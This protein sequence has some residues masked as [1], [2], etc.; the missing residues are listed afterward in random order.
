[1]R[2]LTAIAEDIDLRQ[3]LRILDRRKAIIL[4]LLA[5][6]TALAGLI[7]FQ[8]TP[9]YTAEAIV[10]LNLRQTKVVDFESVMS[11]LSPEAS[12]IR[13]EVDVLTSRAMVG[14]VV[15]RLELDG[16]PEFN[17]DLRKDASL[18]DL[19]HPR[20]WLPAELWAAVAP[21]EK[22]LAPERRRILDRSALIDA[23][24]RRLSASN[25]GRSYSIRISFTSEDP[26]KAALIANTFADQYLVDQLE[27]KFEATRRANEWLSVRLEELR[28]QVRQGEQAVQAFREQS[29]LIETGATTVTTQQLGELNTQ[30]VLAR[31]ERSQ[32]EARLRSAETMV[33]SSGGV[34]AAGDVLNSPLI[35]RLREEES[36][37][38]RKEA[39][40]ATRYGPRHPSRLN[41]AAEL[42]DLQ[43]KIG[44]EVRK[45]IQSLANEVE[46]ARAKERSLQATL[47][48]L[49][50]KAGVGLRAQVQLNELEREAEASRTLYESFLSRFKQTNDQQDLQEADARVISSAEA[51]TVPS[52]P[53]KKLIL[54]LGFVMGGFLGVLVAFVLE[55]L[56]RGFR[57]GEHIE[58]LTGLP[59]LGLVPSLSRRAARQPEDYVLNK[60]LSS[61]CE[62]LRTIRT[63]IHFSNVDD[64]PKV[65][66]VTS[67]VP[68]EGKSTFCTSL[69]RV[70]A[71]SGARVL[72]I[73]CD[74]RRPRI[75]KM[76][77]ADKTG[78][79]ADLLTGAC[80]PENA[81]QI[82]PGSGLHYLV[83]RS[84]TPNPQDLLGSHQME[85][86]VRSLRE[87]Y[88]LI[89]LDTP[90][91]M[92]VS[93]AAMLAKLSDASLFVVRWADTP[94]EV[95]LGALKQ[96]DTFGA[97]VSGV[98]LSQVNV[99]KHAK[100]GYG[101]YGYYYGRYKEY[102]AN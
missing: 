13:S 101:D 10:M 28:D 41:V 85:K 62:A 73:D 96:L 70:A 65:V 94:R 38:R 75:G 54:A 37:V 48:E 69:A 27:A 55:R 88:D 7:A 19:V 93:D 68:R 53:K 44:E 35:Q 18:L 80:T 24:S 61:Y 52:F 86:L 60:P 40:L 14:R 20:N 30:L 91:I 97:R 74:L 82:D 32:A 71:L 47:G 95:V 26:H 58:R 8:L 59:A 49:E 22:E 90:P 45:I 29:S 57:G 50:V 89:V 84:D 21:V 78:N 2:Q 3:V 99:T 9:R 16:D 42:G 5:L 51:P 43:K 83:A 31:A 102:Y 4:G 72:L 15:D 34:E 11:G 6:T 64:P 25:D 98:V 1:M 23:V 100:Y 87:V 92:A 39:E 12:V 56:D 63:A 81:V 36:E 66:M 17:A 77:G 79:V 76:L 46:V 33:K 67:S